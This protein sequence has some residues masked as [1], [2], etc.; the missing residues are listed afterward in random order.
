[1]GKEHSQIR[2]LA[3]EIR[4]HFLWDIIKEVAKLLL[5]PAAYVLLQKVRQA[6]WD[7]WV[8]GRV[9]THRVL[10]DEW[11][12]AAFPSLQSAPNLFHHNQPAG[13]TQASFA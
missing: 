5:V 4:P 3:K 1:M 6:T 12:A 10:C 13:P 2:E 8:F 11:D 7:W 9:P